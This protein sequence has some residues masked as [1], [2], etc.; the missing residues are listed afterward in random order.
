MAWERV[1]V[2]NPSKEKLQ[3]VI[4]SNEKKKKKAQEV[5]KTAD[6]EIRGAK[7]ALEYKAAK[8]AARK[9]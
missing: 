8:S 2:G 7:R 1:F 6:A 4:A 3:N 5:I 9:K